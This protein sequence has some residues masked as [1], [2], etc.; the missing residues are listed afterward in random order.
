MNARI[1]RLS[2]LLASVVFLLSAPT[3]FATPQIPDILIYEGQEYPIRSELLHDYFKKFPERNPKPKDQVWSAL[4]RGYQA[5]FE[6]S[7]GGIYLKDII[8]NVCFGTPTSALETVVPTGE[9][10]FV[11][12]VTELLDSGYG[13]NSEDPY[14][15]ASLDAYEKYAFFQIKN[16]KIL[17]VRL[18]DNK[19]YRAFKKKQ[20]E[21]YKRTKDYEIIVKEILGRNP[22][23]NRDDAD[24]NIL[25]RIFSYTN[26]FLVK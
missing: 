11:D 2:I 8:I 24:A 13:E 23:I 25:L 3:A 10:L 6:V 20:F 21:A 26:A 7:D 5:K 22:K 9:R 18:F 12:W 17:E 4:W 14:G 19:G 1:T 16:G 15:F